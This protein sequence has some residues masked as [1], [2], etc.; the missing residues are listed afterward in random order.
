MAALKPEREERVESSSPCTTKAKKACLETG[1]M[2]W[3][4]GRKDSELGATEKGERCGW[5]SVAPMATAAMASNERRQ[6]R[7]R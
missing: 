1:L 6:E 7:G 5:C 2:R 4:N 3:S